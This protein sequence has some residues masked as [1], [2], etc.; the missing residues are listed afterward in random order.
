M[1]DLAPR[2]VRGRVSMPRIGSWL[3]MAAAG[4]ALSGCYYVPPTTQLAC[5]PAPPPPPGQAQPS[6]AQPYQGQPYQAQPYQTQPPAAAGCPTGTAAT[7][8]QTPGYTAAYPYY[9]Y[10]YYG[11]PY[12]GYY[13]YPG[14]AYPPVTVGVGFGFHGRW[15]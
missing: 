5:V 8:V 13:G 12:Y 4:V 3:V 2:G 11:Y 9:G 15:R 7:Y 1:S 14:Y 6:Q 10:P